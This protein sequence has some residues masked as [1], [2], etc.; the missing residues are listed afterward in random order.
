MLK[1]LLAVVA[2]TA[3]LAVSG[4]STCKSCSSGG[5]F[6]HCEKPCYGRAWQKNANN[7]MEF[8]DTYFLNY[9]KYDPYRCDPCVGH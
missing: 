4:C 7:I 6:L 8:T 1:R 3:T 9:D 5:S 2:A